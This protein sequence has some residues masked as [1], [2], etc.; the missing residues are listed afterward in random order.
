MYSFWWNSS[1]S[2]SVCSLVKVVRWRLVLLSFLL[3]LWGA[4]REK[5]S[6]VNAKVK[7]YL[8]FKNFLSHQTKKR[9][10]KIK[11]F[12]TRKLHFWIMTLKNSVICRRKI[13]ATSYST[14]INTTGKY[15]SIAF[16]W[17]GETQE[18]YPRTQYVKQACVALCQNHAKVLLFSFHTESSMKISLKL[19]LKRKKWHWRAK[20]AWRDN[21]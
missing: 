7:I 2:F 11:E 9:T 13:R 20:A 17:S 19:K 1:S 4:K 15:R 8:I 16:L 3:R 21:L 10:R 6:F 14:V 18:F 5:Q 12:Q